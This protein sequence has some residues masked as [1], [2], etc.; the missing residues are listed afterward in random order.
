MAA[1]SRRLHI[2]HA[3]AVVVRRE[4]AEA[5]TLDAVAAEAGVSKGGLLYHFPTKD[6]LIQGML[7]A[8]LDRFD[9]DL[10]QQAQGEPG[11]LGRAYLRVTAAAGSEDP[12]L[13][14]AFAQRP[15]IIEPMR[16]RYARWTAALLEDAKD[17][18]EAWVMRLTADGLW[19]ADALN[20]SPP[21]SALRAKIADYFSPPRASR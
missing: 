8:A 19:L 10:A 1:P 13:I 21:D 11:D 5:L 12:T 18:V 2:L 3:A 6:A 7:V 17:P 9:D 4:G 14:A 20:L 16:E 15:E